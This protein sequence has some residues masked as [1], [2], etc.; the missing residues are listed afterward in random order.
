MSSEGKALTDCNTPAKGTLGGPFGLAILA[1]SWSSRLLLAASCILLSSSAPV[2]RK[3]IIVL[4][5][6]DTLRADHLGAYGYGAKTSPFLDSLAAR[7]LTF[8]EVV[9]P[10]PATSPSHAS[11]LTGLL[12]WKHGVAQ[13]G[14]TMAKVDTLAMAMNRAGYYTAGV[15]A[16][17]HLGSR[18]GFGR[19]FDRFTEPVADQPQDS[20]V[21]NRSAREAI[22]QYL[23]TRTSR[24]LFLFVHY[25][26]VHYPYGWWSGKPNPNAW[27][28]KEQSN[29]PK[30][31]A[32]YD[33]GVRHV[34]AAVAELYAYLRG[35]GLTEKM[36]FCVIGDHG[37]QIGDHGM[38]IGHA[39]IYAET[40]R[41]P[42]LISGAGIPHRRIREMVSSTD[43]PVTLL[44]YAGGRFP[45]AVDG[46]DLSGAVRRASWGDL[47]QTSDS[48]RRLTV[49]GSPAYTRSVALVQG[50]QWFIKNF[51]YVYR[52]AWIA[53]PVPKG[54]TPG[55]PLSANEHKDG[56]VTYA[57]PFRQY[58][59]TLVSLQ[60]VARDSQC[61][62]KAMV[63]ILPVT[64]YFSQPIE[65]RGS[66]RLIVPA[67]RLD[68]IALSVSPERCAGS[69]TYE[70]ARFDERGLTAGAAPRTTDLYTNLLTPR[71]ANTTDELYDLRKD[72]AMIRNEGDANKVAERDRRLADAFRVVAT[73]DVANQ[74]IPPEE[75]RRLR[76]LGY[77]H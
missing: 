59:P 20:G 72:P 14:T 44:Q 5:S 19:G 45:D 27:D 67:A 9:V 26:D 13:N 48:T 16:V 49:E 25:F 75:Q 18:Y 42:L 68:A 38:P 40:V 54:N 23:S 12:P 62:M 21:V 76:S 1:S 22:D 2:T 58:R 6:I 34:D 33:E 35:K 57:V 73:V 66:I 15:V 52:T 17:S 8:E 64:D 50:S 55:R 29:R 53:T 4:V 51:D 46:V 43:V 47:L 3:P 7:G 30:Q 37:E 65:F 32:N 28:R 11:I 61:A 70:V 10:L 31:I 56:F 69:T 60:H 36:I 39:D 24:P 71:K 77:F 74:T 63:R 41:V